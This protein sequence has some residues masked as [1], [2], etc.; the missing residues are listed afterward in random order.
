MPKEEDVMVLRSD[1]TL[2]PREFGVDEGVKDY[3]NYEDAVDD[4]NAQSL[5]LEHRE[6]EFNWAIGR[7]GYLIRKKSQYGLH[8]IE[9]FAKDLDRCPSTIY[10]AIKLYMTFTLE[11]IQR[12]RDEDIPL[13]RVNPLTRVEPG[14][15]ERLE[16]AMTAFRIND[17]TLKTMINNSNNGVIIP[18]DDAGFRKY[19]EKCRNGGYDEKKNPSRDDAN[20]PDEDDDDDEEEKDEQPKKPGEKF[21][22]SL[23]TDCDNLSLDISKVEQGIDAM[24]GIIT[25]DVWNN[26]DDDAKEPVIGRLSS[27]REQ[28]SKLNNKAWRLVR[29]LPGDTTKD[30]DSDASKA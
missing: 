24:M 14:D 13:R 28:L 27:L 29:K 10:Q 23:Q 21:V 20:E 1:G 12:M 7:V 22:A 3:E 19:Y 18:E 25:G 8:D 26:L 9:E 4:L 30:A 6:L 17:D 5:E 16:E 2:V 11:D 15:R